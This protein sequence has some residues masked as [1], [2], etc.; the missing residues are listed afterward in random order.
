MRIRVDGATSEIRIENIDYIYDYGS[1]VA[2]KDG[3]KGDFLFQLQAEG[4]VLEVKRFQLTE[5]KMQK[6]PH[7][8][9]QELKAAND[10][11]PIIAISFSKDGAERASRE[12]VSD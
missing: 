2:T 9:E 8:G 1:K 12:A 7:H 6:S 5:F 11:V 3:R 4:P 10:R